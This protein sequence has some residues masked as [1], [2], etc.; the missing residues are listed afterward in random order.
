MKISKNLRGTPEN[1][2][3]FILD[4]QCTTLDMGLTISNALNRLFGKKQM[5]ILMGKKKK[6]QKMKKKIQKANFKNF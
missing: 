1:P 2:L 5:R 4:F 3:I 6:I